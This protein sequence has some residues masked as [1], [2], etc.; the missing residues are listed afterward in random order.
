MVFHLEKPVK[1]VI[2]DRR[3]GEGR[4]RGWECDLRNV[5]SKTEAWFPWRPA[6]TF[7]KELQFEGEALSFL[8]PHQSP[9]DVDIV[10]Y[11]GSR[12]GKEGTLSAS[13]TC[14][15]KGFHEESGWT[16]PYTTFSSRRSGWKVPNI[17]SQ[18]IRTPAGRWRGERSRSHTHGK[19]R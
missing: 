9:H 16:R 11:L 17:L 7:E 19:R 13:Y 18:M 5:L 6:G 8:P 3:E 12:R 2:N 1:H 4:G 15:Q 10:V 14:A